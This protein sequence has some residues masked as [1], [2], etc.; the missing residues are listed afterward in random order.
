M[1][2][3]D[4]LGAPPSRVQMQDGFVGDF[5]GDATIDGSNG[6]QQVT[7]VDADSLID[8]GGSFSRGGD[9]IVLPGAAAEYEIARL[10]SLAVLTSGL[11]EFRIP[12]GVAGVALVF[13]DG[14]R[15]L[16]YDIAAQTMKI[17]DQSFDTAEVVIS[18]PGTP[19]P[20]P[21]AADPE[22][23]ARVLMGLGGE[24]TVGGDFFVFGTAGFEEVT[25][26]RGNVTL[27]ASFNRGGDTLRLPQ[28]ASAYKAEQ[29]GST[30]VL[31]SDGGRIFVPIG[32]KGMTID[33]NGD[34]RLLRY[35]LTTQVTMLGDQIVPLDPQSIIG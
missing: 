28:A 33:F 30:L 10:G 25:Y 9:V 23:T 14:A 1:D 5:A 22:A 34:E 6:F 3:K 20:E 18:A 12:V 19:P 32:T 31:D 29:A 27:D 11:S 16:L 7:I 21:T 4:L 2:I 35:D 15:T 13:D 24:A 8:F 26:L 17:G